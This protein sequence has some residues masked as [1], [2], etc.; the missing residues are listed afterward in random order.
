VLLA[1]AKIETDWRRAHQAQPD[2]PVPADM[3]RGR[4]E[5]AMGFMQFL[6]STWPTEAASPGAP[7]DPLPPARR[8]D[9]GGLVPAESL[10]SLARLLQAQGDPA[11]ARP[12]FER[13]LAIRERVLGPDH[14]DTVA[15]RRAVEELAAEGGGAAEA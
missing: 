5:H 3:R 15:T 7:R 11:A 4:P 8:D 1:I 13:A 2:E 10:D 6:P 9:G 12:L 14:P